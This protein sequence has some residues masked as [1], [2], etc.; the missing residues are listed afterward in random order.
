MGK[1]LSIL[2]NFLLFILVMSLLITGGC[3]EEITPSVIV[4]EESTIVP[5]SALRI[6]IQHLVTKDGS[7]DNV[8]DKS[9]CTTVLFP[10]TGLYQDEETLFNSLEE[11]LSL[12]VEAL[13][14]EWI[15][16][17]DVV[18]ADH[19]EITLS[20]EEQLEDI[21]DSCQ[22][23]GRDPDIECIDFIYPITLSIFDNQTEKIETKSVTTDKEVYRTFANTNNIISI[24]FPIGL[25]DKAG[26]QYQAQD[27][28]ELLTLID[29]HKDSCDEEDVIEFDDGV[30]S[31]MGQILIAAD[32]RVTLLEDGE[33]LTEQY[34]SYRLTFKSDLSVFI[35]GDD[36]FEG[37]WELD[38]FD[39]ME[40]L[41][42]GFDTE[43]ADILRLNEYW[44]VTS[45]NNTTIYLEGEGSNGLKTKQL[46][47]EKI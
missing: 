34:G 40:F 37:E 27:N 12:G 3:Q 20:S 44:E 16:P 1:T 35:T 2:E 9:S 23:G 45:Y 26:N 19:S 14:I 31:E 38:I 30:L 4:D 25:E 42:I 43:D 7:E 13:D 22:E 29:S 18:L 5:E 39:M 47:L 28:E 15:Y 10:L 36:E 11:V 24:G 32:W 46:I 8:I 41:E 6:N 17:F 21:Q 33:D